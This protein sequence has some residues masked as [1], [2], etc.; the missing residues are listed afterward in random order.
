[1][2]L[3]RSLGLLTG[4][5]ALVTILIALSTD[6]WFVAMGPTFSSHSGLWPEKSNSEVPGYGP[7]SSSIM[8]FAAG[9]LSLCA[10]CNGPQSGY[11]TL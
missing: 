1:M 4:S 11:E 6:F 2:E 8:A 10:H 5:L 7:L 9:S 3:C